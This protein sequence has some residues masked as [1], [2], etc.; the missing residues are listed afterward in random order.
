MAPAAGGET[1]APTLAHGWDPA[2]R[3]L[4]A[5]HFAVRGGR[6]GEGG[7][8]EAAYSNGGGDVSKEDAE[9]G[10]LWREVEADLQRFG[11]RA[12]TE[13]HALGRQAGRRECEPRLVPLG[14]IPEPALASEREAV[15][16]TVPDH[17]R[18]AATGG[19][20]GEGERTRPVA[21][22]TCDAWKQLHAISAEEGLVACGYE[23]K[24]F[25]SSRVIQF[26]KLYM[27]SAS[28]GMY[29]CPLAMTD[30][31]ARV[32]ENLGR[33]SVVYDRAFGHLVSRDPRAFWTSGQWMTEIEGGSDV[34]GGTETVAESLAED[35]S[36]RGWQD[37]R[38][39]GYK[40]FTS[41][42]D[43]KMAFALARERDTVTGQP[44]QGTKGLSLFYVEVS[45]QIAGVGAG[46]GRIN[47][48]RLKD[49]LGT[50]QLPTAAFATTRHRHWFERLAKHE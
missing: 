42:T 13:V 21:L 50:R 44:V 12:V 34:A 14:P 5:A 16:R 9:A 27:F 20:A 31:A 22:W 36:P 25:E 33:G 4:V 39:S 29:S 3:S 43:A 24:F 15:W 17:E 37:A 38:L 26:A 11:W 48:E 19:G 1:R 46:A 30:G 7:E 40:W 47:I 41:A 10:R 23:R 35:P 6:P 32:C 28:S 49:K 18:Y 2:L 8:G 45:D